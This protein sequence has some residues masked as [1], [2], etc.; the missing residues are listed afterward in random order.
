MTQQLISTKTGI[1]PPIINRLTISYQLEKKQFPQQC[2]TY[3]N[4]AYLDETEACKSKDKHFPPFVQ[5]DDK[6]KTLYLGFEKS[7]KGGPIK[8]FFA[9][10]ELTYSEDRKPKLEWTYSTKDEWGELSHLDATEALIKR[11]IL[12]LMMPEEFSAQTRF[13]QFLYWIKGALTEGE[14]EAGESPLL[15]GVYPNTAWAVQAE[16]IKD[17]ILGS[18]NG[19][20]NQSFSFHKSP[21]LEGVEL[22]V[23]EMLSD[24]ERQAL[25]ASLGKQ[26]IYEKRDE[27]GNVA[28][29]WV[30]W[31]EVPYFFDST[32]QSRHYALDHASGL[33][34][35]GDGI[36]G[37]IPPQGVNNIKAFSYRAGGGAHGNVKAAEIKTLKTAVAGVDK[38]SNP[39][40]ADGGV[41]T[42]T[43]DQMLE[44]G[45]TIISHRNRA[46]TAEDFEWLAKQASRKVVKARC[47]PNRN[48]KAQTERGWVTVI[49]VPDSPED[50]PFPSLELRKVVRRHLEAHSA[51][52]ISSA[53]HVHVDGPSYVGVGITAQVVV[54]SI[55]VASTVD[56]E[57]KKRLNTFFHPLTGGPE[58]KGWDFG[59]DVA[60]SDIYALLES[61]EGVD[62]VENLQF[63]Y[64]GKVSQDIVTVEDHF[65]V[66][67]GKHAINLRLK[68][69]E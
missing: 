5:L 57:V 39:I 1:R 6:T 45:P 14:Y 65:L 69:E 2:L 20:R 28:E 34:Q 18:S 52:T 10:K 58:G 13:G 33:V 11:E 22:R 4:L 29:S 7:F 60:A 50:R 32:A 54:T 3:N 47:L 26:A 56:S 30:L 12:E 23:R 59:R 41:D 64:D 19:E 53:K 31:Q 21:V 36:K 15:N 67:N 48:N 68:E 37:V 44:I 61:I 46:V 24:E 8:L 25:T 17:E 51:N 9:A 55:D 66:A 49:I 62:H 42:A 27:R 63:T 16:T 43:P 40:A 38:V 35:F